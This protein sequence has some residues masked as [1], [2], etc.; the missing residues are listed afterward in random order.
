MG[1][2]DVRRGNPFLGYNEL[3]NKHAS[4]G[5]LGKHHSEETKR[6]ISQSHMGERN[7]MYGKVFTDEHRRKLSEA[8]KGKPPNNAELFFAIPAKRK[9]RNDWMSQ[10]T[11]RKISQTVTQLWQ[12]PEY[13]EALSDIHKISTK[14][15]WQDPQFRETQVR[16]VLKGLN[17]KPNKPEQHLITLIEANHLP[18][19]YVG[20]GEFILGSRCPDFLNTNGKKQL[21]ELFGTYWHPIF[22]VAERTEHFRNYGFSLLTIWEDELADEAK[23]LKK[24]KSFTRR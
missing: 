7:P 24:I 20:D 17:K 23:V 12:D 3:M 13:R 15:M 8:K 2:S 1:S 14:K 21:I 4:Y 22:D 6:K 16:A 19:K 9:G 11:R 18:F 10:E 5:M